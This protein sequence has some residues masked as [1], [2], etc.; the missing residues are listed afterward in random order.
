MRKLIA[1]LSLLALLV[2]PAFAQDDE[3]EEMTM[4]DTIA[5]LVVAST[6]GE[7]PEFTV[8]LAALV[9]AELVDAVAD[10]EAELTVFAPTDAAFGAL[11]EALEVEAADLLAREDLADILLYHVVAGAV[12]AETVVT[13]D[14][15]E[16]ETL[17]G[18][19]I[20]ISVT[21]EGVFLNDDVQVIQTDIETDNGVIHVIDAV[22]LPPAEE[23]E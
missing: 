9:E 5:D 16:V 10:P 17:Q 2:V 13:L 1:L 15:E 21:D 20:S 4:E 6:E 23:E 18:S 3:G 8:L 11:L 7:E 22:L 14:G 19:T 12:L